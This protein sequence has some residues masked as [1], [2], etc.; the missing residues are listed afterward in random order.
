[1]ADKLSDPQELATIGTPVATT[2]F[3]NVLFAYTEKGLFWWDEPRWRKLVR[4][5]VRTPANEA[6][7]AELTTKPDDDLE[8]GEAGE[9]G[10]GV[11]V[12][13]PLSNG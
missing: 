12:D 10:P 6:A 9:P 5:K 13:E 2:I 11:I 3:G 8:Q 7:R 4:G 1:M